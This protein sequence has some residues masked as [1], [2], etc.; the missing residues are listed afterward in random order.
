MIK[1]YE[2]DNAHACNTF[3][4]KSLGITVSPGENEYKKKKRAVMKVIRN[5]FNRPFTLQE[6]TDALS[7]SYDE[8]EIVFPTTQT[9]HIACGEMAAR[10]SRYLNCEARK[11]F[12]TIKPSKKTIDI[13]GENVDVSPDIVICRPKSIEVINI[14]TGK[15]TIPMKST[16]VKQGADDKLELYS[17]FCYGKSLLK[18][19]ETKLITASY[20]FLA[21]E[22]DSVERHV[23]NEEFFD[24]QGKNIVLIHDNVTQGVECE[25]DRH[26]K[27]LFQKYMSGVN[28]S[29]MS[30]ADCEFCQY[31]AACDFKASPTRINADNKV[32]SIKKLHL[33][34]S[35]KEAIEFDSGIARINAGAGTGKTLVLALRVVNLILNGCRPEDICLLTFT[36]AGAK[37]MKV[38]CEN[39]AKEFG[40]PKGVVTEKSLVATTFNAFANSIVE[41]EYKSLGFTEPPTV[42]DNV[43][44]SAIIAAL[45]EDFQ[46]EGLDYRNFDLNLK[47][48]KGALVM[49]K[50]CFDIIKK[51]KLFDLED[52]D[53]AIANLKNSLDWETRFVKSETA[54]A[55]ILE[56]YNIY[57]ASLKKN[58]LIEYADQ[59]LLMF[60][61]LEKNP[62]YLWKFGFKHIIVD[63]FQDSDQA[64]IELIKKL[65]EC[66]SYRSLMVVGDDSQSIFSFRGT[67]PKYIV[68]FFDY[69]KDL[70]KN[71]KDM[72]LLENHRSKPEIIDLAN[73]INRLN[74]E[75]VD[76]NLIA[77]REN[78][79]KPTVRGYFSKDFELEKIAESIEFKI[80]AGVK[81]E[82]IAF[83]CSDRFEIQQLGN[84]LSE[85]D[86]PWI[87]LNPEPYLENA[88][89][90]AAIALANAVKNPDN[91]AAL[92]T[93]L[94]CLYDNRLMEAGTDEI[95][96]VMAGLQKQVMGFREANSDNSKKEFHE[97]IAALDVVQD[98]DEL[99]QNFIARAERKKTLEE[100][101]DYLVA[102]E[103]YGKDETFK[104][105]CDY[106]GVVLST[107]HSSKG[108]EWSIVYMS[109]SKF[110]SKALGDPESA[111]ESYAEGRI[112]KMREEKRRLVF[113]AITRARDELHVSGLYNAFGSQKD[114][115]V[116]NMFL[117]EIFE[118]LNEPFDSIDYEKEAERKAKKKAAKDRDKAAIAAAEALISG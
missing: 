111:F 88:K 105:E 80:N 51:N 60:K 76:K 83:I 39:Y 42:I 95:S 31:R 117:K 112:L 53:Q 15:P 44:R 4:T 71:K 97:L 106:S 113:V 20:Y 19:D 46:I 77:T 68:N 47:Y 33:T 69:F 34:D 1:S 18:K 23:F 86:I 114:G 6:L 84:L 64:Q 65:T 5:F 74:T 93:F 8:Y 11:E 82:D 41:A 54:Y 26:F 14:K 110:H 29:E 22:D 27:T 35:Q 13:F 91:T 56:A 98:K 32:K 48:V 90:I 16:K 102:F 36:N 49:M 57:D 7:E 21:R 58:N 115:Y 96:L 92:Y 79:V 9:K 67:S 38:R 70:S 109:L 40:I 85:K 108:L 61:V 3:R 24:K 10:I 45:L 28:S 43:D 116:E 52:A 118:A 66:P 59:E 103:K 94:N 101:V 104:R 73:K 25:Q 50:K 55:K 100:E 63:E 12:C 107:A 2:L 17:M 62:D 37:E 81:P 75:R 87:A 72:Y 99:Y 89:V 78:G 30:E